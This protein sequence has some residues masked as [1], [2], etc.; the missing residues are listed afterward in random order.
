VLAGGALGDRVVK[1]V[2]AGRFYVGGLG[3]LACAPMAYLTLASGSLAL[4]K[5]AS[6]GFGLLAGLMIANIFAMACD[7]ISER[8]YG[9]G[10]GALNLVGGLSG[11]AAIFC[12][13]LW[14]QSIGIRTLMGWVALAT[15]S[16]A[17]ALVVVVAAR[18]EA[19]RRRVGL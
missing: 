19:D 10:A 4:L 16:A 5:L 14:K 18:F 2:R 12:T 11:G 8:N 3:L 15:A 13:G 1:R 7:V 6:V 9:F 17:V